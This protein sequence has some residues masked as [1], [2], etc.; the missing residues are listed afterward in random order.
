MIY[1]IGHIHPAGE[2]PVEQKQER[3]LKVSMGIFVLPIPVALF[4]QMFGWWNASTA[5][6]ENPT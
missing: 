5:T 2:L 4:L 1:S 6:V 3:N